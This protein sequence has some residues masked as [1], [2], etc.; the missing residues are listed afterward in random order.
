MEHVPEQPVSRE[1]FQAPGV[2]VESLPVGQHEHEQQQGRNIEAE[3]AA[4]PV[5]P[6]LPQVP[7]DDSA[8]ADQSTQPAISDDT[9]LVAADED[10]IEKEWVD[11]AKKIIAQTK[12][13]PHARELQIKQLQIEY[14]KKR[15]GR[16]IGGAQGE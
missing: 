16:L 11:K 9:P 12:E 6:T 7:A 3:S 10:L 15:Y 14:V 5:L 8:A 4:P 2:S 13:D 1:Q